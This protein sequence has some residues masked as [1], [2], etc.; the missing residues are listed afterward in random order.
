MNRSQWRRVGACCARMNGDGR[1]QKLPCRRS[2]WQRSSRNVVA[3]GSSR[4]AVR[5][6]NF[7]FTRLRLTPI[8][9]ITHENFVRF[10]V[11][12]NSV[13][14][15]KPR[16]R[17]LDEPQGFLIFAERSRVDADPVDVFRRDQ[18]FVILEIQKDAGA[19]PRHR[20]LELSRR[21]DIAG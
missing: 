9:V 11:D 3:E 18:Q 15:S 21:A 7:A 19:G 17:A 4:E 13:R 8:A 14:I 6:P 10:A 12:I 16:V 20:S 5:P 2:K 1:A